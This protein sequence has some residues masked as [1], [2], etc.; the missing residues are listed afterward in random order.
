MLDPTSLLDP[1]TLGEPWRPQEVGVFNM[2]IAFKGKL[3]TTFHLV[4]DLKWS[5]NAFRLA[6]PALARFLLEDAPSAPASLPASSAVTL[7]DSQEM[8][9]ATAAAAPLTVITGPPGTGK[10]QTVNRYHRRCVEPR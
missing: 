2:V 1:E 6:K 4:K 7:N 5:L 10:S 3:D 8:A 9:L